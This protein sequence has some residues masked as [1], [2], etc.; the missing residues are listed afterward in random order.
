MQKIKSY[1]IKEIQKLLT[2]PVY[3]WVSLPL[4]KK[5]VSKQIRELM[6][7]FDYAGSIA[8]KYW[9]VRFTLKKIDKKIKKVIEKIRI[10]L[11]NVPL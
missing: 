7:L 4:S 5:E 11:L 6:A 2:K 9:Y 10:G 8:Q 3:S 1:Y